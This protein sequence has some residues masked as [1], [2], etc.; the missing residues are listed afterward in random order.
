MFFAHALISGKMAD[1]HSRL[2]NAGRTLALQRSSF[3]ENLRPFIVFDLDLNDFN[4]P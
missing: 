2:Y 3:R 4:H 1:S